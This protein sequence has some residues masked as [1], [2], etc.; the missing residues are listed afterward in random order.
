M[1]KEGYPDKTAELAIVHV[2]KQEKHRNRQKGKEGAKKDHEHTKIK[3][4]TPS[5]QHQ[6]GCRR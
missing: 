4:S 3:K 2:T 6:T 1:N 5:G